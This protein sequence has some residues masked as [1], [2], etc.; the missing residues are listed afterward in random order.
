ME[1]QELGRFGEERAALFLR[2]KGCRILERNYRCRQGE[3]DLIARKGEYLCFVEVKL[4]RDDSHG[5]AREFVTT[6]KQRRI[7]AAA[8]FWL[9]EHECAL[10]PR[11]DVVE[12]YAPKGELGPVRI[13]WI[14]DAFSC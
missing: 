11:F 14:E 2:R 1:R 8:L 9:S 10:Q 13:H 5:Q 7:L 12:V 6:A 3:I 4:R